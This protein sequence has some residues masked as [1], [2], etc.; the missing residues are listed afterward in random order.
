MKEGIRFIRGQGAM[1][2]LIVMGFLMTFLFI[3]MRTFLPVFAK[4]VFHKGPSTY[5]MFV[6]VSG[7]GSIV[8]ALTFAGFSNIRRKGMLAL[9]MV[10][11]LGLTAVTFAL[12]LSLPISFGALCVSGAAMM[13]AFASVT[14]LV[15]LIVSNEMRGRVMSVY[16]L[17]FRGGMTAGNLASGWLV[18]IFTAPLVVAAN[19]VLLVALAAYFALAQRRVA[20]L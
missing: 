2:G 20:A 13:A 16:N 12:S 18:P 10:A 8:G 3:P 9:A 19:G 7:M 6:S 14:S 4:D 15:Q 11:I 1:Q 17:A 5:A